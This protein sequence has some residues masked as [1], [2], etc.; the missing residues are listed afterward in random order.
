MS[1]GFS[2]DLL[3]LGM[4]AH[5]NGDYKKAVELLNKAC[6]SGEAKG[7]TFLGTLYQYGQGV[8]QDYKKAVELYQKGCDGGEQLGCDYY[9]ELNEKRVK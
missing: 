3:R 6:D 1:L 7:C 9:R 5:A 2:K 4:D 8:K